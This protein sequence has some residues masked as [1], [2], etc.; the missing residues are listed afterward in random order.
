MELYPDAPVSVELSELLSR[1]Q[2]LE[3][4]LDFIHTLSTSE[5]LQDARLLMSTRSS[6]KDKQNS[7]LFLRE[8][9]CKNLFDAHQALS[10]H[11]FTKLV[12]ESV[13]TTYDD[14]SSESFKRA[15][16]NTITSV[17]AETNRRSD[18]VIS[19]AIFGQKREVE[20]ESDAIVPL[21]QFTHIR[22][23][24][25]LE[26]RR[27]LTQNTEFF[28]T[29]L[30]EP[31]ATFAERIAKGIRNTPGLFSDEIQRSL[32]DTFDLIAC[33]TKAGSEPWRGCLHFLE[34]QMNR[35]VNDEVNANLRNAQRG[36]EIGIIATI[37]GYLTLQEVPRDAQQWAIIYYALRCG[38]LMAAL[39]FAEGSRTNVDGD[40]IMALRM[41]AQGMELSGA[42]K[43]S[44]LSYLSREVASAACDLY[45]VIVLSVLTNTNR[46]P[47]SRSVI[48]SIE[49][50]LWLRLFFNHDFAAIAKDID[51]LTIE[52]E[53]VNPFKKG[54]LY[55]LTGRYDLAAK[56]FLECTT[57][58]N[59]NLH[60]VLAMHV[61][62]LIEY[63][64]LKERLM[65][66]VSDVFIADPVSAVRYL[67]RIRDRRDR[68]EAIAELAVVVPDGFAV[69]E[70]YDGGKSPLAIVLD[71][72]EQRE[73]IRAAGAL[74]KRRSDHPLAARFFRLVGD[75]DRVI[76]AA[77]L[78]LVQ[79]VEGFRGADV[80]DACM[81]LYDEIHSDG[82]HISPE[83]DHELKTLIMIAS[84]SVLS[85]EE[86]HSEAA[87]W[88]EKTELFPTV[89]EQV[90]EKYTHI[91]YICNTYPHLK[92][93]IAPAIVIALKA[94]LVTH[95]T[96]RHNSD[97]QAHLR[98]K[99]E[100]LVQFSNYLEF[101]P[102]T[103]GKQIFELDHAFKL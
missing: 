94:Y 77:C 22:D 48:Q 60:V 51:G 50:W 21:L 2:R 39:E 53:A 45:K 66:F 13:C 96:A 93:A 28:V 75:Y 42:L 63:S 80:L 102:Q 9:K 31:R 86:R 69:A 83:N 81:A 101:L 52:E 90:E 38:E 8:E 5:I 65:Q 74:A 85:R 97:I 37:R 27:N 41:F 64:L 17:R 6:I 84:A 76:D 35:F 34:M 58:T 70:P 89:M 99:S 12:E 33:I 49:E 62:S 25:G 43:T 71:P 79:C 98:Q 26:N 95:Q 1:A 40:V 87:E 23:T 92:R 30:N 15:V 29:L 56:W 68:I 10:S 20:R 100:V 19:K 4:P 67:S 55:L 91:R 61:S 32:A 103:V 24:G 78:D 57:N 11:D 14:I 59:E 47:D 72:D 36:G 73:A 88:I 16:V 82:I 54:Q 44:L 3:T 18:D 7:Q 46:I